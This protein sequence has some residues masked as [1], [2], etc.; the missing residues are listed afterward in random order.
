M[1]KS[2][3]RRKEILDEFCKALGIYDRDDNRRSYVAQ[4]I[5]AFGEDQCRI[6]LDQTDGDYK[7]WGKLANPNRGL[8][9]AKQISKAR[10]KRASR[11]PI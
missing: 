5:R 7:N 4:A 6:W 9:I 10:E 2:N 8:E 1:A 11:V 3:N